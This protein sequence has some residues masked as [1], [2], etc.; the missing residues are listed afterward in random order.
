VTPHDDAHWRFDP[1]TEKWTVLLDSLVPVPQP[2][3]RCFPGFVSGRGS[4]RNSLFLFGGID[5]HGNLLND[6]WEYRTAQ[7]QWRSISSFLTGNPPSRR[8]AMGFV[9]DKMGDLYILGGEGED[10]GL[11]DVF[12][13]PL[14]EDNA[15]LPKNRFDFLQIYDED[16]IVSDEPAP[17]SS[18][19][20]L[21]GRIGLC[22]PSK[23]PIYPCN[24]KLMGKAV[25]WS[26]SLACD[27]RQGCTM[28]TLDQMQ[29]ACNESANK[30]HPTF[31]VSAGSVISVLDSHISGCS[32][33][34]TGGFIRA[35]DNGTVNIQ[36]STVTKCSSTDSGGAIALYGSK[37]VVFNSVFSYCK[38]LSGS[39]G[40]IWADVFVSLPL[41]P[42]VSSLSVSHSAFSH[43]SSELNGGALFGSKGSLSLEYC[44][45][46]NNVA[47]GIVGGGAV[48]IDDVEAEINF[49]VEE[50]LGNAVE[51]NSATRGGGGVFFWSGKITPLLAVLCAPGYE[52]EWDQGCVPC[53]AGYY[54]NSSGTQGC[55]QCEE[56]SFSQ[57]I[58]ASSC[59]DCD[60]GSFSTISGANASFTCTVC[61]DRDSSTLSVGSTSL[62]DCVCEPGFVT[63]MDGMRFRCQ[64]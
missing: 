5:A 28:I 18:N 46:D 63:G 35:Y 49:E 62:S 30:P 1:E 40:A 41:P 56:G 60:V 51:G 29:L 7:T 59:T 23:S 3:A 55:L 54:K 17:S 22:Y 9:F 8:F 6:L 13:V 19:N 52:G 64:N 45:F 10:A 37:L 34:V 12:K 16:T 38:S 4:R 25:R 33:S 27:G 31:E 36:D 2:K 39:G 44:T 26:V 58:A 15:E 32:S 48:C 61:P 57:T 11:L 42:M 24:L 43:C 47:N 50:I 21:T 53:K 14:P 20:A